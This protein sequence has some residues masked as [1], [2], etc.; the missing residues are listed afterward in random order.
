MTNSATAKATVSS[1]IEASITIDGKTTKQQFTVAE[2]RPEPV[3]FLEDPLA[4]AK[5]NIFQPIAQAKKVEGE[6][7]RQAG[8]IV[9]KAIQET[10]KLP[11]EVGKF[12]FCH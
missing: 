1:K 7:Q 8:A 2:E 11:F 4:F 5:E 9:S 10:G 12:I 3:S 6:G